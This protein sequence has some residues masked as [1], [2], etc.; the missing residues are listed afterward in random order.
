VR[1]AVQQADELWYLHLLDLLFGGTGVLGG[2][3]VSTV[4][5][6]AS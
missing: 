1:R 4:L 3:E 2:L 6:A 5:P